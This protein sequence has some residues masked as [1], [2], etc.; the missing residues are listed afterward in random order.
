MDRTSRQKIIRETEDLIN[1]IDETNLTDIYRTFHPTLAEYTVFSYAHNS[2]SRIDTILGH[3]KSLKIELISRIFSDH[4][5]VKVEI[6]S[7]RKFGK[8]TNMWK[9][10]NRHLECLCQS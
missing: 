3:K 10:Y 8:F 2:F 4:N 5:G 6:N 1:P 7:R 9:L